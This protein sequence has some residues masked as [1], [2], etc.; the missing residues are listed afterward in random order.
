M[1]PPRSRRL[2]RRSRTTV[3]FGGAGFIAV[4]HA[5]AAQAAG[6]KVVAVASAGGSSA[7]HLAGELDAKR[8]RPEDLP[9]GADVLV[10]ATPPREHVPLALQG[11]R[12]GAHVLVEKP[13]AATLAGADRLVAAAAEHPELRVRCAEN[14]V[15]SPAWRQVGSRRPALGTLT[16]L[17]LRTLQPPPTWGH[18]AR[19]LDVGGVLYDLG[20]HAVALA[21]GLADEPV[22][23]VTAT[24]RSAREDGADDDASVALR[25]RSGLVASIEV[26]WVSSDTVWEAQAASDTG[27]L[28]LELLPEVTLEHDGEPVPVALRH[29]GEPSLE[30][31]GYVDQLLDLVAEEDRPGQTVQAARDVLEVICAGYRSAGRGEEV[32]LP[33][34][35]DLDLTPMQLWKG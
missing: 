19:P 11:L 31:F 23:G 9:A 14:L 26:S 27:V 10:V 17:S 34:A 8:V 24:L 3:A 15:H 35:E 20:P 25:F 22:V 18:F 33:L 7:R 2:G 30:Q 13:L 21:L 5:L 12:E 28:R 1:P 4:V 32:T 16:H 6:M 29:G